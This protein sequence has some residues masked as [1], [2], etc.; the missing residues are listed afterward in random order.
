MSSKAYVYID[1]FNL[2]NGAVKNTAYKWL[3]LMKLCRRMLPN[4][5]IHTIK[6]FSAALSGRPNHPDQPIRQQVYWRALRTIPNLIIILGQ[7]TTHSKKM[8]ITGCDP[9]QWIRVD[10]TD[11]K[12][13]DVNLASHLLHDGFKGL[14]E[15][16]VIISNDSDL[17]E[18][19]RMVKEVLKKPI[20]I[21]NPHERHSKELHEHATFKKRIR[22]SDLAASQFPET[23]SD[24]EGNF[25]KPLIW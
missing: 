17:R 15:L 20:G 4:D 22:A 19:V 23:L 5:S 24:R 11:E 2:Y 21:L 1:G 13:T 18:P 12:G 3:D 6:F 16:A 7:F 8:P 9:L 10:R 25:R 14:F